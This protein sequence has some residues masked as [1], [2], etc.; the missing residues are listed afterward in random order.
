M[1][2][3]NREL[4]DSGIVTKK[5]MADFIANTRNQKRYSSNNPDRN[6]EHYNRPYYKDMNAYLASRDDLTS[7]QKAALFDAN[8]SNKK[9]HY[10]G[11]YGGGSGRRGRK[12]GRRYGRSGKYTRGGSNKKQKSPIKASKYKASKQ[13]YKKATNINALSKKTSVKLDSVVPKQP[14]P[15]KTAKK[16][17]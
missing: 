3:R 7:E 9:Y 6:G 14:L 8:N 15:K 1:S 13:R 5:Q 2:K 4:V 16:G 12:S 17:E 10:G 11:G